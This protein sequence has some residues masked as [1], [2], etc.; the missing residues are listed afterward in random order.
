MS[1]L[2]KSDIFFDIFLLIQDLFKP[3]LF[4]TCHRDSFLQFMFMLR[5]GFSL[6]YLS[7]LLV[8]GFW[9]CIETS[10]GKGSAYYEKRA[11]RNTPT[12]ERLQE[13]SE[14]LL[15]SK[16]MTLTNRE[17][18]RRESKLRQAEINYNSN[19]LDEVNITWYGRWLAYV[20]RYDEAIGVFSEGIQRYPE[21]YRLYRHRGHQYI[22]TRDFD[23]AVDDLQK[24]AFYREIRLL[25]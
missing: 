6:F 16:L 13:N 1:L 10:P 7:M 21:S 4:I 23:K 18:S 15:N 2:L 8:I 9:S 11:N 5:S 22:I 25:L 17:R 20:S 24:A 3:N 19:P 14:I 12:S